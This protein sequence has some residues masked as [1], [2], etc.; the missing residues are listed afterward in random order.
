V[1]EGGE[2]PVRVIDGSAVFD[3][4]DFAR[5]FSG[6]LSGYRWR[7]NLDALDDILRGGFGTPEGGF[8]LRWDHAEMS[9]HWLGHRALATLIEERMASSHPTHRPA[10]RAEL[11]LARREEGP[12]LFD[13][14][15]GI[16]RNHGPGGTEARDNVHLDLR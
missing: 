15:V 1:G 14:L 5:E 10:L 4:A 2:L 3:L 13:V 16:I 9:K 7:G 11:D 8:V 6:A 12:T